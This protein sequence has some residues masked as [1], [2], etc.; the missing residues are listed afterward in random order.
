MEKNKIVTINGQ[1]YDARTGLRIVKPVAKKP[2]ANQKPASADIIHS[3]TQRS[4]TLNRLVTKKPTPKNPP[5]RPKS[6][7]RSMD[8][9]RSTKITRF[10]PHPIPK[11]PKPA[12]KSDDIAPTKHPIAAKV[13][14]ARQA[15]PK[16]ITSSTPKSSKEIKEQAIE[17]A[18]NRPKPKQA[19][20]KSFFSRHPKSINI[21]SLGVVLLVIAG[22]L[23]YINLPS[24]SVRIAAI[25]ANVDATYPG[26]HPDGYSTD[27]PARYSEGEVTINFK[28]NT[29]DKRF[30][31]KQTKST[32]DST[33]VREQVNQASKGAFSATETNGL[34]IFTYDGNASWVNG[35]IKYDITG[36]APLSGDQIRRM[37]TSF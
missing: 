14:K 18:I 36:D 6:I 33:A 15:A 26:Y 1:S 2:G 37:A 7:G 12:A 27:G 21:I 22:Y 11:P 8:I 30:T 32:L 28:A 17:E 24:L 23:T 13:A 3:S 9:A 34:T 16:S 35:G 29:G 4:Q 31:I 25:Q 5:T 20:K 19:K 10:A